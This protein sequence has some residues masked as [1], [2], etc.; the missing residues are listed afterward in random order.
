MDFQY[1]GANCI[2]ITNKKV[3]ILIDDDLSDHDLKSVATAEDVAIFTIKKDSKNTARFKIE[4]PGEYEIAEV[5]VKGIPARAH[6][7]EKDTR[8]TI[9]NIHYQGFSIGVI[10]HVHPNLTE[11]QLES[12]GLVDVLIL[13]VGGMGYTLDAT[14][15]ASLVRK[16]EPKIVIPT[17]YADKE[18]AY[19]VPQAELAAFLGEMAAQDAETLDVF[20]LKESELGDKARVVVL[21]R[22]GK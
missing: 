19:E 15:A 9:Y 10:G 4:G 14:G 6:L 21:K 17:H 3:T 16:I 1:Y 18:V 8:A 12:L 20:K 2:K 13:P 5:S 22:Q 7:D 11:D